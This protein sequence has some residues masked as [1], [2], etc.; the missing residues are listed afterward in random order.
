MKSGVWHRT[1]WK[2]PLGVMLSFIVIC[3]AIFAWSRR[4][5]GF[6]WIAL[7]GLMGWGFYGRTVVSREA[8]KSN[9]YLSHERAQVYVDNS[10]VWI[11]TVNQTTDFLHQ[12]LAEDELFFALPYDPLYYYLTHKESPTRQLIFFDH[13]NI[14]EEQERKIIA[15]LNEKNIK[16]ILISSRQK[17][18][19]TG[20]GIFGQSY[21]PLIADYIKTN[22]EQIALFGD[23]KNPP[24]WAWNHG[25]AIFRRRSPPWVFLLK[26]SLWWV[27]FTR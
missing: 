22:F 13:I 4:W 7:F 3:T 8:W 18:G 21:C 5:Q 20:L 11:D 17:S 1:L 15:E 23:W 27:G 6:V 24:G 16:H 26:R 2:E 25:T 12:T 14:P 19:E 10:S 9:Q